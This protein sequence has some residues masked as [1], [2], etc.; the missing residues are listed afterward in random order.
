MIPDEAN[1]KQ[2]KYE[3]QREA[4]KKQGLQICGELVLII[5]KSGSR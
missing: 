2:R 5:K 4:Q 1:E 3:M